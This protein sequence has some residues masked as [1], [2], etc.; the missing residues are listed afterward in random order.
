M[1]ISLNWSVDGVVDEQRY[2]CSTSP[3]DI[4]NLPPP[5]AVLSG[6][7]RE[8]S[9]VEIS[10]DTTYYIRISAK[11]GSIEKISQEVEVTTSSGD[12][13][14]D[15]VLFLIFADAA[16]YPSK[17]IVDITS[18]STIIVGTPAEIVNTNGSK[19]DDGALKIDAYKGNGGLQITTP[20]NIGLSDFTLEFH[21]KCEVFFDGWVL[22]VGGMYAVGGDEQ[23]TISIQSLSG[24]NIRVRLINQLNVSIDLYPAA[25][26]SS[27]EFNHVCL[28]RKS[29]YIYFFIDGVLISSNKNPS[30]SNLNINNKI[31]FGLKEVVA[32]INSIRMT[33]VARYSETGFTPPSEKYPSI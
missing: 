11:K 22:K 30:H 17:N 31:F 13:H 26:I 24:S 18:R 6:L 12:I 33:T 10:A 29:G 27:S 7:L 19:Y 21:M 20:S 14:F 5:K 15:K 23:S 25:T 32:Y 4:N 8:F 1:K 28:M 9:D 3:I 16:T 2:F